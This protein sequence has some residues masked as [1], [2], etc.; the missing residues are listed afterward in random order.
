MA[1]VKKMREFFFLHPVMEKNFSR[2]FK[3]FF[4]LPKIA[5]RNRLVKNVA[6]AVF[7]AKVVIL[8]PFEVVSGFRGDGG[9]MEDDFMR[10]ERYDNV[11]MVVIWK[12]GKR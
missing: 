5:F 7:L 6:N 11:G 3:I 12:D 1:H 10:Q 8:D 2:I 4:C 9:I